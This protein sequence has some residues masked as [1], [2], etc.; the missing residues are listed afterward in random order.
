[1]ARVEGKVVVVT[2]AASGLG[3]ADARLLSAEGARVIMTDVNAEKGEQIAVEIGAAFVKQDVSE[4]ASWP[5]LMEFVESSHGRLDALV[6]N[7]GVGIIADIETTTTEVWRTIMGIHLD[8]TFWG[9]QAAIELMKKSGG[10]SIVNMSSAAALV[11]IPSYLAYSAAK[12]GIRSMS[13]S[14]AIHCNQQKLGIRCNSVHPGAISTP[15]VHHAMRELFGID[16]TEQPDV[17]KT[18]INMGVGEPNDIAYMVLYLVSDESK[19][20]TGAEMV[21]DNGDTVVLRG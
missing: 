2:G 10:G 3:E 1:M 16:M 15:M 7:A 19:H 9:C 14:I 4:E 20:V 12:G 13:K 8:G 21:I 6:N 5:R 11:G 17:E 18:R